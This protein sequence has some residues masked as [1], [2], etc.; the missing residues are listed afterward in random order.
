M[1]DYNDSDITRLIKVLEGKIPDRIPYCDF[2]FSREIIESILEREV[3]YELIYRSDHSTKVIVDSKD[4]IDFYFAIGQD[5]AGFLVLSP[6]SYDFEGFGEVLKADG[7]IKNHDI[8]KKVRYPDFN[9]FIREYK[10]I[11][12]E[13]YNFAKDKNIGVTILTGAIFQDTHQLIGFEDFMINLYQDISYIKEVLNFFTEIYYEV[14]KFICTL[15]VPLFFYTDNVAYN[16]GPFFNPKLF[17]ELY[18]PLLKKVLEPAKKKGL[19]IIFDS[20][21]DIEWLIDDLIELGVCAIHPIDPCGMDIYR[22]KEKYRQKITIMGNVGQDFPL[23]TGTIKDVYDDVKK[24]IEILGKC[25]RYVLKS[26]H[27]VGDNV[28]VENFLTMIK[29]LHE[30]GFY[31]L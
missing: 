22:I 9:S 10:N 20:D 4:F 5:L 31:A 28:R 13:L 15:D 14:S 17:K 29:T 1:L 23:S 18:I 30:L 16:K 6:D 8:F 11:F 2:L 21:G 24:R 12:L 3:G 25:G 19:P 7:K 27:D 26:S